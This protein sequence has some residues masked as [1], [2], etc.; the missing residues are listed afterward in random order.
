MKRVDAAENV[1]AILKKELEALCREEPPDYTC[2]GLLCG[3]CEGI[4]YYQSMVS[5][6]VGLCEPD[7]EE[8]TPEC[9][10]SNHLT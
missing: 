3:L 1:S 2:I 8:D 5:G 10:T 7:I 9:P 6:R 4:D